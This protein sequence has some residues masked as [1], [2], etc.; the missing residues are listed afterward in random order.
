MRPFLYSPRLAS[1]IQFSVIIKDFFTWNKKKL[2]KAFDFSLKSVIQKFSS[3]KVLV[4]FISIAAF[5]IHFDNFKPV[6]ESNSLLNLKHA[7]T[8]LRN[9]TAC[10]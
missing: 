2:S 5:G 6:T 1:R 4:I 3:Q 8:N 10:S 7:K 9:R